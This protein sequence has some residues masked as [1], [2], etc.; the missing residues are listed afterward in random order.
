MVPAAA[1]HQNVSNQQQ[2]NL[3]GVYG[4]CGANYTAEIS[5]F[6]LMSTS[7]AVEEGY[8]Y[9]YYCNNIVTETDQH[10]HH[11][12]EI[13]PMAEDESRTNSVNEAGSSSKDAPED[14]E[15]WLQLTIGG[16]SNNNQPATGEHPTLS[17]L[18]SST[19]PSG[20]GLVELDLDLLPPGHDHGGF[21]SLRQVRSMPHMPSM[22]HVPQHENILRAPPSNPSFRPP[23]NSN[24]S[25]SNATSL[26]F[27]QPGPGMG[28]S[29]SG[30]F[31]H[32][33]VNW[34]FRPANPYNNIGMMA[35]TSLSS[36]AS[37]FIQLGSSYFAR[38]FHHPL[39]EFNVTGPSLDFRVVDA[40]RRPQSG[41]WF[42]LQASQNQAKEPFLPQI[43]KS[44]LRIKD[45]RMTVRLIK[46]Y[47][48][49][50]LRLESESE[51]E[52]TCRGQELLPF[53]TLQ[54]VR[55]NIWSRRDALTLLPDSSTI[56]HVMVLHYA[57]TT[58]ITTTTTTTA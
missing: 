47:L 58:T 54:H 9:N 22:F 8:E 38:P 19:T 30:L 20:P 16:G 3:Y 14:N 26:Y 1:H 42:T 10:H 45:G 25:S 11:L 33:E 46:K 2:H 31:P 44:Y 55:D 27:Q 7:Q 35:S 24:F 32:Q 6:G 41:I 43:P 51:V 57:R 56:D 17:S 5:S 52:I 12:A 29:S 15:T 36:S 28:S 40:P 53:L 48:V 4:G 34:A 49:N 23:F 13:D 50:K 21:S 39:R 18:P 37:S